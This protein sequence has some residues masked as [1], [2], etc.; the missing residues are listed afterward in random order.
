[1]VALYFKLTMPR[2]PDARSLVA[3]ICSSP[4]TGVLYHNEG[5]GRLRDATE[6]AG[7]LAPTTRWDTGCSFFDY[8]LDGGLDLVVVDYLEFDRTRVPEPGNGGT[9]SG[10]A[11]P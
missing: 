6:A 5:D 1:M 8:D 11:W 4:T 7:L 10:R 2:D 9:A 3:L